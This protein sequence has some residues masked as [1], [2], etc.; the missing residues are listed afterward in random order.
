MTLVPASC[1]NC[2][3]TLTIDPT[4]R[5]AICPFCNKPFVVQDAINAYSGGGRPSEKFTAANDASI[6]SM[7]QQKMKDGMLRVKQ[8]LDADDD[9]G[10]ITKCK[11]LIDE[12]DPRS[13]QAW[14]MI[15]HIRLSVAAEQGIKKWEPLKMYGAFLI[16]FLEG[17]TPY[18]ATKE[19]MLKN[20]PGAEKI[21]IDLE[22]TDSYE[23][24]VEQEMELV[25]NAYT[26]HRQK[27]SPVTDWSCIAKGRKYISYGSYFIPVDSREP[28]LFIVSAKIREVELRRSTRLFNPSAQELSLI[29]HEQAT[30]Y[31]EILGNRY[32]EFATDSVDSATMEYRYGSVRGAGISIVPYSESSYGLSLMLE[33]QP[34]VRLLPYSFR[35]CV[36]LYLESAN[37]AKSDAVVIFEPE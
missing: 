12:V 20:E 15:L 27:F 3:S 33:I 2:H 6:E 26:K 17:K 1:P 11:Q 16:P 7:K 21:L 23:K 18:I 24:F 19:A 10:A 28:V 32:L 30:Y 5:A 9:D 34:R 22:G 35:K 31:G 4:E 13:V 36:F 25:E 37:K 14:H 8:L 29:I